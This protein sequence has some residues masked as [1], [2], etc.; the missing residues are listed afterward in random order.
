MKKVLIYI[1]L[2]FTILSCGGDRDISTKYYGNYIAVDK[3]T[4]PLFYGVNIMNN[5][6]FELWYLNKNGVIVSKPVELKSLE[7][8]NLFR[9]YHSTDR[10]PIWIYEYSAVDVP[11]RIIFSEYR[12]GD[13]IPSIYFTTEKVDYLIPQDIPDSKNILFIDA[14]DQFPAKANLIKVDGKTKLPI[15]QNINETD[16]FK[17]PENRHLKFTQIV[18]R[19]FIFEGNIV[20]QYYSSSREYI[21]GDY[22][23]YTGEQV[24]ILDIKNSSGKIKIELVTENLV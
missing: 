4:R 11:I 22:G 1:F 8:D 12:N 17:F 9:Y 13:V 15:L 5:H 6:F 10:F 23:D 7:V 14:L 21:I 24:N 20:D 19:Y 2:I 18:N 16:F 3:H